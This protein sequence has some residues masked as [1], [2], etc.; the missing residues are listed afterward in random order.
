MNLLVDTNVLLRLVQRDHLLHP[1]TRSAILQLRQQKH[2][3][4]VVSQNCVEFWNVATR[5]ANRNGLGLSITFAE[6]RLRLVERLFVRLPD[7]PSVYDTWRRIVNQYDVSGVQVHDARLV[8][9]MK[10]NDLTH[11]LTFNLQDFLR[12]T[13]EQIVVVDPQ[14]FL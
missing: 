3:L 9:A 13:P 2:S 11:I 5:P 1:S 6:Y 14:T 4:Y 8:A 10:E 12:F 7:H